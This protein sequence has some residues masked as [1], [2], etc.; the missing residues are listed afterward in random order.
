MSYSQEGVKTRF[1]VYDE[2]PLLKKLVYT[3]LSNNSGIEI[4]D[5]FKDY[6]KFREY[7]ASLNRVVDGVIINLLLEKDKRKDLLNIILDL[8]WYTANFIIISNV[9]PERL[10]ITQQILG[11]SNIV[12]VDYFGGLDLKNISKIKERVTHEVYKIK[13]SRIKR[14]EFHIPKA[15]VIAASTGGPKTLEYIFSN[16]ETKIDM[17]IFIV[18]HMV[19]GYTKQFADRLSRVS[20]Y[21]ICEGRD[22]QI[23]E[24]N[25]VYIAPSGYH[26][27]VKIHNRIALNVNEP[28]NN[29][30]PSA[31][32]LFSSA[33][34]V[35]KEGLLG[36]VLTGM[37][38]DAADGIRSVKIHGGST[39]A[40][41]Q[42]SS[43]VFGMPKAAIETGMVD[44]VLSTEDIMFEILK[45]SG[46]L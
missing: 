14:K 45:H 44:K 13:D 26:M 18:Q 32:V 38:R 10:K 34:R 1:V 25:V 40:Q 46:K 22:D 33:S 4:L 31:D 8:R 42:R 41:T 11:L 7:L 15:I 37:G 23:A 27:E 9:N 29:V 35:Y 39:I 2:S 16:L 5:I 20:S 6:R 17:P 43:V 28:V 36:I 21:K 24:N 30:R 12:F 3:E 19:D